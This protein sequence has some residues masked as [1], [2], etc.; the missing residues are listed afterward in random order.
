MDERIRT[1]L[2]MGR[3][4][5][6]AQRLL[7]LGISRADVGRAVKAGDLVRVRRNCLVDGAT[8]RGVKPWERHELRA[9]AVMAGLPK[10]HTAALSHHSALAV[11]GVSLHGVDDRVHIVHVGSGRGRSD[12]VVAGHRPVQ[13]ELVEVRDGIRTVSPAVAC[14]QVAAHFGAEAGLVSAD[15]ALHSELF[16]REALDAALGAL[17][18]GRWSRAPGQM[19]FLADARIE[20]AAESRARWAFQM[21]GFRQ[22]TPQVRIVDDDGVFVARVD[23]LYEDL[24]VV[25]EVDGLEKYKSPQDLTDEKLRE[26]RLR[27]LGYEIVRLTWADLADHLVVRRKVLVKVGRAAA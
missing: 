23:F 26:D 21:L 20:S 27:E 7:R 14:L 24:K 8:W 12:D 25:I 19:S 13:P 3:G 6:S 5:T 9:R 11:S 16:T 4:V 2:A 15:R 18:P 1:T 10:D 17:A 22:P